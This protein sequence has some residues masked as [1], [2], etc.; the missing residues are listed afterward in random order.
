MLKDSGAVH[1]E[2]Q[3]KTAFILPFFKIL[4]YDI[5][6]PNEFIPEYTA[7][8]GIKKFEKVDYAI[9]IDDKL[10]ILIECKSIKQNLEKHD[11][12]LFRY[13]ASTKA[14]IGVLTNGKEYK[15]YTDLDDTNKMDQRPFLEFDLA[16]LKDSQFE[17]LLQFHKEEFD[18]EKISCLA[19]ELKYLDILKKFLTDNLSPQRPSCSFIKYL[20]S[21]THDGKRT[22]KL[23]EEFRP[24]II[25]GF[26][27]YI[28]ELVIENH[29]LLLAQGPEPQKMKADS[30]AMDKKTS[31]ASTDK[32]TIPITLE[33]KKTGAK[34]KGIFDMK[35]QRITLLKGSKIAN[36]N[37]TIDAVIKHDPLIQNGI[38]TEDIPNLSPSN[39]A[40]TLTRESFNGWVKWLDENKNPINRYRNK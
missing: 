12:Q 30:S 20:L 35:T 31:I 3:T 13:F 24:I 4:G 38:L 28:D 2:E 17:I 33:V 34:G 10:Q 11:S 7:D 22:N 27:Q 16:A 25:K 37:C 29:Q 19:S 21:E 26:T 8:R 39:A 32:E 6:N 9:K 5:H 18:F 15:F 1:N 40:E 23:I 14:K 36:K